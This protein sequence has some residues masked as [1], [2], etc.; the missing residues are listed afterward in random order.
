MSH[1]VRVPVADCRQ[2]IPLHV[3][4]PFRQYRQARMHSGA[5]K[6]RRAAQIA[7]T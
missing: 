1:A 6:M 2:E 3:A 4:Q 7:E 5:S